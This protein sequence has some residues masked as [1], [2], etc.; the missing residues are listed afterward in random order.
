MAR[1][2]QLMETQRLYLNPE[3]K[4]GDV[5]DALGV[6]RNAISACINGQGCTFNQF[7]NDYRLQHAKTLLSEASDM[8]IST[9][10]AE[11]GFASESSFFRAFKAATSMS[12]KE[13]AAQQQNIS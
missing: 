10:G 1:I 3:L 8:K 9:V 12:P 6:H 11:S 2:I 7:V 13:W 4:V 5:A